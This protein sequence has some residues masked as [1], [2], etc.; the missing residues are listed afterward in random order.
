MK[1]RKILAILLLVATLF[2][3]AACD[4]SGDD[5]VY[6]DDS[7][8]NEQTNDSSGN[9]ADSNVY[10]YSATAKKLHREYCSSAHSIDELYR[11]SYTGTDFYELIDKGFSFCVSCC[12]EESEEYKVSDENDDRIDSGVSPEDASYVVNTKTD[13]FHE[14]D[15]R[16]AEDINEQNRVYTDLS[17]EELVLEGYSPCKICKP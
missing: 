1:I 11:K 10:V 17:K 14:P 5:F 16:F 4:K 6:K 13:K 15:C 12:P 2:S 9:N 8:S 7:G 3:L